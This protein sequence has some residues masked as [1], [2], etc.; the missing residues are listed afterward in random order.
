MTTHCSVTFLGH[1]TALTWLDFGCCC[2]T[3]LLTWLEEPQWR[4][5]GTDGAQADPIAKTTVIR[6]QWFQSMKL[7]RS[8][9][10]KNTLFVRGLTV[11]QFTKWSSSLGMPMQQS[12]NMTSALILQKTCG[13]KEND[14]LLCR[15]RQSKT[16]KKTCSP[17]TTG[18]SNPLARDFFVIVSD[19]STAAAVCLDLVTAALNRLEEV[20]SD[21]RPSSLA[22]CAAASQKERESWAHSGGNNP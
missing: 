3:H 12:P 2:P 9:M 22:E 11:G 13:N 5:L 14:T 19:S 16:N 1:A 18:R 15:H 8:I 17:H 20:E 21:D 6:R 10:R 4:R 7:L